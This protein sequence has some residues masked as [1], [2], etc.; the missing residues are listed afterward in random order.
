MRKIKHRTFLAS[1]GA[2]WMTPQLQIQVTPACWALEFVYQS[3]NGRPVKV[4]FKVG[5]FAMCVFIGKG[6]YGSARRL[7]NETH[8]TFVPEK[9]DAAVAPNAPEENL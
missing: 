5:C 1:L 9:K 8:V 7:S 2:G 3:T 6:G 4:G